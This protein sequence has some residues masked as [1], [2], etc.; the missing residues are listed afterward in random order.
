MEVQQKCRHFCCMEAF[1]LFFVFNV[2]CFLFSKTVCTK[3][4]TFFPFT[5]GLLYTLYTIIHKSVVVH[6]SF[7]M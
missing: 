5:V 4:R 3:F 2:M 1:L 7:H 6:K